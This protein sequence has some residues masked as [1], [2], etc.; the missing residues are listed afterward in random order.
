MNHKL[1][2]SFNPTA[3]QER[4]IQ[5]IVDSINSGVPQHTL[6]G[7]TGAGKT[8]IMAQ[9]MA[10]TGRPAVVMTHNK[11]LVAQ[12]Y[13]EFKN[14]FP[15]NL[16]EYFVSHFD[17]FRP[18]SFVNG[19]YIEKDS[20]INEELNRL[21]I[22]A[23]TS[24][25]SGRRDIVVVASVSCIFGAGNPEQFRIK[26]THIKVGQRIVLKKFLYKL[27]ESMYSREYDKGKAF[28]RSTFRILGDNIFIN[29]AHNNITYKIEFFGDEIEAISI[30][31]HD[32]GKTLHKLQ[33][34]SI[35]PA[36]IILIS[37][38]NKQD[39]LEEILVDLEKQ[40][41]HFE[42]LGLKIE[43]DRI[44]DRTLYDI[45]MIKEI[46]YCNGMENYSRYFDKRLPGERSF[47]ILDYFPEDYIMFIDES[48]VTKPLLQAMSGG[49]N[50]VKVSLI[51]NGFR[52]PA[53]ADNRPLTLEEFEGITNQ[54]V[55]VSATPSEY[56]L[57]KSEG[58]MSEIIT[59][60]TGILDPIIEV[61]PM[62]NCVDDLMEE[63]RLRTL[64]GERT[65]V[66]TISKRLSEELAKYL[67]KFKI[68][69]TYIH[70][71]IDTLERTQI[72]HDLRSGKI[73]VLIGINLLREGLDLPEVSLVAILD[74]DKEGFL[75]NYTSM[76]QTI[77]RAAR[78]I[79]GKAI[80]YGNRIT[81]SMTAVI[82]ET[83]R[84]R[85]IQ[86]KYNVKHKISPET[87]KKNLVNLSIINPEELPFKLIGPYTIELN[88]K[89]DKELKDIRKILHKEMLI[90]SKALDFLLAAEIRDKIKEI[91]I[92]LKDEV[93]S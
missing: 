86:I 12:L 2:S 81:G 91:Q 14:F 21:R 7:I 78:N 60:P 74:A 70:S 16:V 43:A 77:G 90:A 85:S 10:R 40:I 34:V 27:V 31:E 75:R 48:H 20:V 28:K 72:L 18:E 61:R 41:S 79:N 9:V 49:S 17:Y 30:I 24:L 54:V 25:M 8:F 68:K 92:K 93:W 26:T 4:V 44:K 42:S 11:T 1:K 88:N 6:K 69:C 46:G 23:A 35:Y 62:D 64:V 3:D 89:S 32:S 84:R 29:T 13:E 83:N 45:E 58:I 80:L 52:L 67:N 33:E 47:C 50:G 22:S 87:I 57:E 5:E 66:T 53:A 59:R 63:I 15:E 76:I 73:D 56:E 37:E 55:Y 19:N 39:V 65:L 38:D 82:N 51:E 36:S 71:E